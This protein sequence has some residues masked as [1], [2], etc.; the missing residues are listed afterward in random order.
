MLYYRYYSLAIYKFDYLAHR[1]NFYCIHQSN[2]LQIYTIMFVQRYVRNSI[3]KLHLTFPPPLI[4]RKALPRPFADTRP[5]PKLGFRNANDRFKTRSSC[6]TTLMHANYVR[7]DDKT[8]YKSQRHTPTY[9]KMRVN[10]HRTNIIHV[11]A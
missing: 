3:P 6:P 1:A 2:L 11:R 4:K 8:M 9:C 7:H 5:S 10:L